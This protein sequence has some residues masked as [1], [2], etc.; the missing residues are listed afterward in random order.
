LMILLLFSV[1]APCFSAVLNVQT[2]I[3]GRSRLNIQGS[4]VW[5]YHLEAAAPGRHSG[6]NDPT[7]LNGHN[8]YPTW[9]D[10]PDPENRD[11]GCYSSTYHNLSPAL[12]SADIPIEVT[13]ISPGPG[14]RPDGTLVSVIEQPSASNDYTAVV[15]FDDPS[16]GSW[17][18]NINITY[19][20]TELK[21]VPTLSEWGM[22]IMSLLILGSAVWMI[23]KRQAA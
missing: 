6:A 20:G 21:S 16:G 1:S 9:P 19:S 12:A 10:V 11:C 23:R 22:M 7:V 15:E 4:N 14:E 8:W 3:D 2:L 5:W 13:V 17:W 18:Y